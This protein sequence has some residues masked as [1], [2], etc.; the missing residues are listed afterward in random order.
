MYKAVVFA[1]ALL[2]LMTEISTR[3][4]RG[5]VINYR[6][7]NAAKTIEDKRM[8]HGLRMPRTQTEMSETDGLFGLFQGAAYGLQFHPTKGS[9]CFISMS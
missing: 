6:A 2:G 9:P 4:T 7:M 5:S 8:K 3:A 1:L